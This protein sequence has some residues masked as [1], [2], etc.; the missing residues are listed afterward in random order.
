[1]TDWPAIRADFEGSARPVIGIARDH[2][3]SHTA[4]NKKAKAEGWGNP[5]KGVSAEVSA[6]QNAK[7][8]TE[9]ETFDLTVGLTA[10]QR[11]FVAEYLIDRNAT[12]AA[13]RAGYS[14]ASASRVLSRNKV[15]A[16][17]EA[18]LRALSRRADVTA[19]RVLQE[20]ARLGFG[21]PRQV[22]TWGADGVALKDS[23]DLTD[24]DAA[25][26]AEVISTTT[27]TGGTIRLKMHDK[28]GALDAM[29]KHLRLFTEGVERT[30][31]DGTP[32]QGESATAL[33]EL[34]NNGR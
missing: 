1:V 22:M 26:I 30:G 3:V 13:I 10:R 11:L 4:I 2:G 5:R 27:S 6:T 12:Q 28:K 33:Y 19:E 31:K 23:S 14:G 18:G 9:T 7:S 29:A 8:A 25:M 21:N 20:Y 32:V 34:P 17:V 24:D 15:S 16:A